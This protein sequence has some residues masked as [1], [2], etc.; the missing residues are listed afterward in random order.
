MN[1]K[2]VRINTSRERQIYFELY[3]IISLILLWIV[4]LIYHQL[5]ILVDI[6]KLDLNLL[7]I[8]LLDYKH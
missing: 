4:Y 7:L 2:Q 3:L 8:S 6:I 1:P 5:K